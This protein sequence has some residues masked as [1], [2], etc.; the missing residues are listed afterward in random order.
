MTESRLYHQMLAGLM[1]GQYADVGAEVGRYMTEATAAARRELGPS[2]TNEAVRWRAIEL[3]LS[4]VIERT[5][6][7][8][9]QVFELISR[10]GVAARYLDDLK[11]K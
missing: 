8:L 10:A 11:Y 5:P 1:E 7:M 3:A 6:S 9:D 4:M 2:A